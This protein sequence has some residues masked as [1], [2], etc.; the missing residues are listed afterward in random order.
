MHDEKT[1][2]VDLKHYNKLRADSEAYQRLVERI[3]ACY[4]YTCKENPEPA[5]CQRCPGDLDCEECPIHGRAPSYNEHLT[6]DAERLI[7][8]TKAYALHGKDA[9]IKRGRRRL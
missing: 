6:L 9:K 3:A 5:E 7:A 1:I 2:T 8:V 4:K